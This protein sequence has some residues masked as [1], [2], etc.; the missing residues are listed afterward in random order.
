[1]TYLQQNILKIHFAVSTRFFA[2]LHKFMRYPNAT[3]LAHSQIFSPY[4]ADHAFDID[5]SATSAK[6]EYH[7]FLPT[8]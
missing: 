1:M 3:E 8:S 7:T 2:L 6:Q 4:N 5:Y